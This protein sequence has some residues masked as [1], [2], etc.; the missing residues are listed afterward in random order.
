MWIVLCGWPDFLDRPEFR[1]VIYSLLALITL[2]FL[3]TVRCLP[4]VLWTSSNS[5]LFKNICVCGVWWWWRGGGAVAEQEVRA[6]WQLV[7]GG[8]SM[9]HHVQYEQAK[10]DRLLSGIALVLSLVLPRVYA[11]LREASLNGTQLTSPLS[12]S[13]SL[14][15]AAAD[16]RLTLQCV[17]SCDVT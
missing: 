8:D 17:R 5:L 16:N 6:N 2:I 15:F 4:V 9:L 1:Y 3:S 7:G 12:L 14:P 11:L 13:P 10:H